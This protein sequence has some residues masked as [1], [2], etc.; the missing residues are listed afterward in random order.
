MIMVY[1]NYHLAIS[2]KLGWSDMLAEIAIPAIDRIL[3][4]LL[5]LISERTGDVLTVE[6]AASVL[7]ENY[8]ADDIFG[9]LGC[10]DDPNYPGSKDE[11]DFINLRGE[12]ESF[13]FAGFDFVDAI[14]EWD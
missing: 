2:N 8:T 13:M 1:E 3:S 10:T 14:K 9:L 6:D 4:N 12:I 5:W 11:N 7:L